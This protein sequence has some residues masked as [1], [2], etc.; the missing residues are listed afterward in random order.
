MDKVIVACCIALMLSGM[1]LGIGLNSGS[2][3]LDASYK[4]F[5]VVS[6]LAA[7]L[8]VLVALKALSTWKEQFFHN[9]LY[10]KMTELESIGRNVIGSV[11]QRKL[12]QEQ[13]RFKRS[14]EERDDYEKLKESANV[15]F[16][17][18]I[19][20]YR[21]NVDRIYPLLD[22]AVE[23]KFPY[24]YIKFSQQAYKL[25]SSVDALFDGE[26]NQEASNQVDEEILG[27]T[28]NFKKE[29][30]SHWRR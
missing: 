2:D 10:E 28:L 19:E 12:A 23:E 11:Q 3:I 15:S 8:T 18:S 20:E 13:L 16:R 4:V 14:A 9:I 7:S 27:F 1:I 25:L 5:G 21:I 22:K 24:T 30:R 6:G 17:A 26:F 29:L